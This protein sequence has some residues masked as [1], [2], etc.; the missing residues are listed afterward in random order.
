MSIILVIKE[1][2]IKIWHFLGINAGNHK[3]NLICNYTFLKLQFYEKLLDIFY[4]D[5]NF[6]KMFKIGNLFS[7]IKN[8][9]NY[10]TFIII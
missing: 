6:M 4:V 8:D 10:Q 1:I 3:G 9:N 2:P 7:N 5:C